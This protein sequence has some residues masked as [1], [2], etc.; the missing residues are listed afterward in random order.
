M[1]SR[2]G[3]GVLSCETLVGLFCK[4]FVTSSRSWILSKLV[5]AIAW[6]NMTIYGLK[7]E[8]KEPLVESVDAAGSG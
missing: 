8:I 7:D 2:F 5:A 3:K 6:R 1:S 4:L